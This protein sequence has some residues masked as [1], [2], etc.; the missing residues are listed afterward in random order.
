MLARQT[1]SLLEVDDDLYEVY[2]GPVLLGWFEAVAHMFIV[3]KRKTKPRFSTFPLAVCL[4][5]KA[6]LPPSAGTMV[7]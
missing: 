2:Y 3:E 6:P 4:S 5:L 1:V 7:Q